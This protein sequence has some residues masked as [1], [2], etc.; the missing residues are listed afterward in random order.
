MAVPVLLEYAPNRV[1]RKKIWSLLMVVIY[2]VHVLCS[3]KLPFGN[4]GQVQIQQTLF[5]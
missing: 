3:V 4:E 5:N 2:S 1:H